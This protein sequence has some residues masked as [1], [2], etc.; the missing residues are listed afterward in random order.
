MNARQKLLSVLGMLMIGDAVTYLLLT[1]G[2]VEAWRGKGRVRA[3]GRMLDW[4]E[5]HRGLTA[6][7]AVGEAVAGAAILRRVE[8]V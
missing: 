5:R 3:Y 4:A 6:A 2:H 7:I 1:R 8:R